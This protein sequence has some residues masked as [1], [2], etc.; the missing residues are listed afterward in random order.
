MAKKKDIDDE[1]VKIGDDFEIQSSQLKV[2]I[3]DGSIFFR[4]DLGVIDVREG[5]M[6]FPTSETL[7]L[8]DYNFPMSDHIGDIFSIKDGSLAITSPSASA[9]AESGI[10]QSNLEDTFIVRDGTFAMPSALDPLHAESDIFKTGITEGFSIKEG[11]YTVESIINPSGL[12]PHIFQDDPRSVFTTDLKTSS[13]YLPDS[14]FPSMSEALQPTVRNIFTI[15]DGA[16]IVSPI[17]GQSNVLHS[18][19]VQSTLIVR[20]GV[21]VTSPTDILLRGENAFLEMDSKRG[22]LVVRDDAC[23]LVTEQV[24]NYRL[25]DETQKTLS[26]IEW[27]NVGS[28]LQADVLERTKIQSSFLDLS[29]S[30]SGLFVPAADV[31]PY[32]DSM[33][34]SIVNLP[35]D[36][37]YHS[38]NLL[39]QVTLPGLTPDYFDDEPFH[40]E[41]EFEVHDVLMVHLQE[42][43]IGFVKMLR[44]AEQALSSDNVDKVRHFSVSLR[45]LYTHIVSKLSPDTDV[46]KWSTSDDNFFNGRPT[47]KARLKYICREIDQASF[48]KFVEADIKALLEFLNLFQG[49]THGIRPKYTDPQLRAMLIRMEG[50]LRFLIEV[51]KA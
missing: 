43:D 41:K 1:I 11:V 51:S 46:K 17:T 27:S 13:V 4:S 35:S 47:R 8:N 29:N 20:D 5:S 42:M 24:G 25:I 36:E 33:P 19:I 3:E 16:F 23:R 15:D 37:Y 40:D 38:A 39:A 34:S 14:A 48:E 9:L 49:G 21:L 26:S 30:Y 31:R 12:E 32:F 28:G 50:A 45:E 44:G 10:L 22:T 2:S 7:L 18:D 6:V